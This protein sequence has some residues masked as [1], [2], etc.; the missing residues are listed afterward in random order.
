M[1]APEDEDAAEAARPRRRG[2]GR[3]R[4][5]TGDMREEILAAARKE[6]AE[7][8]YTAATVRSIARR[9]GVDPALIHH[10][11]GSKAGLFSEAVGTPAQVDEVLPEIVDGPVE[12]LGAR[13]ARFTFSIWEDPAGQAR[14]LAVMRYALGGDMELVAEYIRQ[15]QVLPVAA[16]LPF[17]DAELR[18]TSA[19]MHVLGLLMGRYLL[20]TPSLV[21]VDAAELE[22]R[23]AATLQQILT[24]E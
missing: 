13:I 23:T 16:V 5:G 20:R 4:R 12:E 10:Y 19:A 7:Q 8:S 6:F 2:R 21:D 18:A 17:P 11:F 24:A 3:P 9:A 14:G 22:A 15:E 1:S